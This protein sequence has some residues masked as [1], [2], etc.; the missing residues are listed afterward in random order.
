V[1]AFRGQDAIQKPQDSGLFITNIPAFTASMVHLFEHLIY[2]NHQSEKVPK[3]GTSPSMGLSLQMVVV[4]HANS[5]VLNLQISGVLL[6]GVNI[7]TNK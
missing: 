6:N 7:Q 1:A 2:I 5:T 4:T 3:R